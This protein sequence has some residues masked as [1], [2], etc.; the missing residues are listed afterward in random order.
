MVNVLAFVLLVC[1]AS[2][3]FSIGWSITKSALKLI[4]LDVD[5]PKSNSS[6]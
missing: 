5:N 2:T 1:L 6:D 3:V 4:G